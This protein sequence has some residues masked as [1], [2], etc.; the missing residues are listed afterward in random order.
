MALHQVQSVISQATSDRGQKRPLP[1]R[2]A[3]RRYTKIIIA[4]RGKQYIGYERKNLQRRL[5]SMPGTFETKI[6]NKG[7][8]Q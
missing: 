8:V 1:A 3:E 6:F 2:A 7:L 5:Q 4:C